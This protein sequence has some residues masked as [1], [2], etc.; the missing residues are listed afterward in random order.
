MDTDDSDLVEF[1]EFVRIMVQKDDGE[2]SMLKH[3]LARFK[4]GIEY[5]FLNGK[6]NKEDIVKKLQKI[7]KRKKWKR[8]LKLRERCQ[9]SWRTK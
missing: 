7:L 6:T 4:T 8:K 5:I 9:R 2:N 3:S 1:A